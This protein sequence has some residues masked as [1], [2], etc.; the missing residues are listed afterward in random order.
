MAVCFFDDN[1]DESYE[2][3]YTVKKYNIEVIVN[4]EIDKEIEPDNNGVKSFG[5]NTKF[6]DRD[7]LI[8]DY[9][10]KKNVLLKDAYYCGHTNVWGTPDGGSKAKFSSRYYFCDKNY[11]KLCNLKKTPKVSKIRMYSGLINE[12]IG[13]PSLFEEDVDDEFVI[14]LKRNTIRKNI[15]LGINNIKEIILSDDWSHIH[16][17]KNNDISIKLTGY[18]EIVL[19]KR[20]NYYD[21]YDYIKETMVYLQLIRPNKLK[22]DKIT[23]FIDDAYYE[24][25]IPI[26]ELEY[27]DKYISNSVSTDFIEFLTKCYNLIPYRKSKSEIRNIPYIIFETSRNL[28]DNFLMFYKFIECYYKKQNIT[29]NFTSY[30]IINNYK[31]SSTMRNEEIENLSQEIICLR[32]HYVH[33]GYFLKNDSL[34]I[35]FKKVGRKSNP[36]NYTVNKIDVDWIYE[37][38]KILYEIVIDIIFK[39]ML[40]FEQYKFEK[41]F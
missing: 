28:E 14:K 3:D 22:I 7:I 15:I 9:K 17:Y 24:L 18:L 29:T 37:K 19:N 36:K 39:N 20:I 16:S 41:K 33:S 31:K 4:Y 13:H 2:C 30:S 10:N 35:N 1:Y 34:K 26:N 23:V 21:I 25:S 38:T 27:S 40:N 11:D 6:K 32:N 12:L 8:I 5:L